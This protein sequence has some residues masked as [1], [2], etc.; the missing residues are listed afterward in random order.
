MQG[1]ATVQAV[2]RRQRC[3]PRRPAYAADLRP[4]LRKTTNN[5]RC[6]A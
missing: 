1:P 6:H 4:A 2:P 3:I 5:V